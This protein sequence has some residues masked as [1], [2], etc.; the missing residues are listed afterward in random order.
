MARNET[1]IAAPPEAVFGLLADPRTYGHWVV[2]SR[3]IR[4]ADEHWPAPGSAFD[5][6]VGTPPL[7]ISD[8]TYVVSSR[9]PVMLELRAHAR[10]LP[11]ARVT[12]HLQPEGDGTRVTM[13]EDPASRLLNLM[14]GPLGHAAIRVRNVESLR[15]L[16]E[17]A[18]G[19]TP[20]PSH[21]LPARDGR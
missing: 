12:M 6:R 7:V 11:A 19:P 4:A 1:V 5:H 20:R 15:R 8:S 10:P 17:L 9:P 3:D 2:G 18:E 13:I 21:P 16:K 14:A